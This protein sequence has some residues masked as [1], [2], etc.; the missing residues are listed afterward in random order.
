MRAGS[1]A[2]FRF[3]L[4][5]GWRRF[6]GHLLE[7]YKRSTWKRRRL[8]GAAVYQYL[9]DIVPG[10]KTPAQLSR[11]FLNQ[12]F[13]GAKFTHFVEVDLSGLNVVQGRPGVFVIPSETP[14]DLTGRIVSSGPVTGR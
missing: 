14:L 5:A 1:S 13:Q 3:W 9:S 8:L 11:H 10:T 6:S 2:R 7:G 4:R 12:P